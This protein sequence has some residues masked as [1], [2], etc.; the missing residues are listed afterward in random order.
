[1]HPR[2]EVRRVADDAALLRLAGPQKIADHHDPRRQADPHMQGVCRRA[3]LGRG[4]NDRERRAHRVL[5]VVLVSLRIAE[6]GEHAVAHVFG[7]E[8]A[9]GGDEAA[10]HL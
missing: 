4:G 5:G 3:Q 2:R 9:V 8:A 1:M 7:D 10:Q 6:V